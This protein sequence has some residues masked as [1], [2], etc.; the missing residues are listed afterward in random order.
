M[1]ALIAAK[2]GGWSPTKGRNYEVAFQAEVGRVEVA[3]Y[4]EGLTPRPATKRLVQALDISTQ[5]WFCNAL[6][7]FSPSRPREFLPLYRP[8]LHAV[9]EVVQYDGQQWELARV[10]KRVKPAP[11]P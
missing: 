7:A 9:P 11:Q 3:H 4:P 10:S 6:S 2:A 5:P 1:A 8:A